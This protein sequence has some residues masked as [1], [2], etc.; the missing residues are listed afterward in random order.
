MA[1]PC[2]P[3][4]LPGSVSHADVADVYECN[5]VQLDCTD[6]LLE[7]LIPTAGSANPPHEAVNSSPPSTF[8]ASSVSGKCPITSAE[9][10][11][12]SEISDS[13]NSR[14]AENCQRKCLKAGP[15]LGSSWAHQK[16]LNKSAADCAF[17]S[18][19]NLLNTFQDKI[20]HEKPHNDPHVEFHSTDAHAV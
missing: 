15:K 16:L 8:S 5:I 19:M 9:S 12:E 10:E 1:T 6:S 7:E 18:C 20:L 2:I 13:H 4:P 14:T 17:H 3:P 11:S